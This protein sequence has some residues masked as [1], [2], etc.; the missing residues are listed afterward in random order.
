LRSVTGDRRA[1]KIS[2]TKNETDIDHHLRE[3][4]SYAEL[5]PYKEAALVKTVW[6]LDSTSTYKALE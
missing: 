4:I 3:V 5:G 6:K 2:Y 1:E